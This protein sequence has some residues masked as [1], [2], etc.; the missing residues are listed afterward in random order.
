MNEQAMEQKANAVGF[1]FGNLFA[2][3]IAFALAAIFDINSAKEYGWFMGSLHGA[4]LP[5]NWIL[6][7]FNDS[8]LLKAPLHTNAYTTWWWIGV[9]VGC[10]SW[11]KVVLQI[12]ITFRGGSNE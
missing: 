2:L 5:A 9:V 12:I 8:V 11:L 6:S 1:L 10:W 3:G 4:W 7:W